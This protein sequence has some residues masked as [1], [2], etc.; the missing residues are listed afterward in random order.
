M[1]KY[2]YYIAVLI[3]VL[4]FLFLSSFRA[5]LFCGIIN[6]YYSKKKQSDFSFK[7]P[8]RLIF[9]PLGIIIYILYCFAFIY[10]S[11]LTEAHKTFPIPFYL[12]S[13]FIVDWNE[14]TF[15]IGTILLSVGLFVWLVLGGFLAYNIGIKNGNESLNKK[16][17]VKITILLL[18]I[19]IPFF[20]IIQLSCC[21]ST[22]ISI[23]Q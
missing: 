15:P 6:N 18:L 23:I 22:L 19:C 21:I 10:T 9:I 4:L 13:I 1:N 12:G 7:I 8:F 11:T 3:V 16:E 17:K 14:V 20:F 5:Y 2:G